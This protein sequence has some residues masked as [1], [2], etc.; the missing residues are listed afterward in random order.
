MIAESFLIFRI[1]IVNTFSIEKGRVL[2]NLCPF[3]K[4]SS[5]PLVTIFLR[6]ILLL[7]IMKVYLL[8]NK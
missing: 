1:S 3:V 2:L 7:I 5:S 8:S 6:M 4:R